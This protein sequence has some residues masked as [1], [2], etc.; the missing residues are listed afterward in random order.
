MSRNILSALT[1]LTAGN[2]YTIFKAHYSIFGI[3]LTNSKPFTLI[4]LTL[5]K[6]YS[7][8]G[9]GSLAPSEKYPS[10][11][12]VSERWKGNFKSRKSVRLSCEMEVTNY[13]DLGSG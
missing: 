1:V 5:E 13:F 2:H 10:L 12:V 4:E 3:V 6:F 9:K 7:K 8:L 11:S